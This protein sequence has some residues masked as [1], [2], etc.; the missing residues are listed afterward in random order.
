[1]DDCLLL[2]NAARG[3]EF[4]LLSAGPLAECRKFISAHVRNPI[5]GNHSD[6]KQCRD[7]LANWARRYVH[8]DAD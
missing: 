2:E 8:A 4:Q 3:R 7:I 6:S 5:T 1:M